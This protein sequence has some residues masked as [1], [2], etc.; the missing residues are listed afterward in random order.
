MFGYP[1]LIQYLLKETVLTQ[2]KVPY[3]PEKPPA[4]TIFPWNKI[5]DIGR[6]TYNH[7]TLAMG[8][9]GLC[10][11]SDDFQTVIDCIKEKTFEHREVVVKADN[12]VNDEHINLPSSFW[13]TEFTNV[14]LGRYFTLL[15]KSQI[16][17]Y[18]N[19]SIQLNV[20]LNYTIYIHD[21]DFFVFSINPDTVP[22][23]RL[24]MEDSLAQYVYIKATNYDLMDRNGQHCDHSSSYSFTGCLRSSISKK[25]ACRMKWDVWSSKKI[26]LCTTVKQLLKLEKEYL[27]FWN[28]NQE[29][30]IKR[31]GC[32]LPCNRV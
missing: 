13:A 32:P 26:P 15:G 9:T 17:N 8:L 20:M 16:G 11:T 6:K 18:F 2:S 23:V 27:Y 28:L 14:D 31:T 22:S 19:V 30:V 21:P 25:V 29:Q 7:S 12:Y 4:I 5:S 24:T 3:D 10:N 1:A